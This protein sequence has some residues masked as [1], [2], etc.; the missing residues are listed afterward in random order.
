MHRTAPD[1]H[2]R[3]AARLPEPGNAPRAMR[4]ARS[5]VR[6]LL[7]DMVRL[8]GE[9]V[10]AGNVLAQ[11]RGVQPRNMKYTAPTIH[12]AAQTKSHLNGWFM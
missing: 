10:A 2:K 5:L 9:H 4:P 8:V 3:Q 1:R 11:A 7:G 6:M 12:S